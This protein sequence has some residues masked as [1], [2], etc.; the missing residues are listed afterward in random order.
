[1]YLGIDIGG[2]KTLVAAID[3]HGNIVESLKFPTPK[4]YDEFVAELGVTLAGLQ[5]QDFK[6]A[7][8]A[9]PGRIDRTHG[10][11]LDFGNLSW[12]DVPIQAD[13]ERLLNCPVVVDNDANLAGLG[14]AVLHP[15]SQTV[16]YITVSTGIGTGVIQDGAISPVLADMEAGHMNLPFHGKLVKWESFASGHAIYDHF[17]KKAMDIHD[18]ASWRYVV[19]NLS[20]GF[21]ELIAIVQPDLIVIGGSVGTYFDRYDYML[22]E[23]LKKLEVPLVPIPKIVQAKRPEEAVIYGCYELIK[24]TFPHHAAAA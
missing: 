14:E 16:L 24:Q 3:D 1:M 7:A 19:R 18:E 6:A 5:H 22:V 15:A 21:F 2:T 17:N 9:A 10:V 11:A 13:C 8:V 12:H 23:E 4:K 20:L